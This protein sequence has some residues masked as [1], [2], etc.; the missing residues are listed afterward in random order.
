MR[1]AWDA[2]PQETRR[3]VDGLVV[4]HS[5]FHSRA[6]LGF[7]DYSDRSARRCRLRSRSWCARFRRPAGARFTSPR[8]P[9]A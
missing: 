2:L 8:T 3:R 1:A 7:T 5:I 9:D 6:K 4:E